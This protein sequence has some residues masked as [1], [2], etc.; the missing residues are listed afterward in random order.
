MDEFK[1]ALEG[2]AEQQIA[3]EVRSSVSKVQK[4]F[5]S[6]V[7]KFGSTVHV[8]HKKEWNQDLKYRWAETFPEVEVEVVVNVSIDSSTLNQIPQRNYK[9]RS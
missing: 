3:T 8:Q 4:E 2:L 7:L 1:S 6:D 9:E 5:R